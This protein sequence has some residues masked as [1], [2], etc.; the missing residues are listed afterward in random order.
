MFHFRSAHFCFWQTKV[1][2]G[3]NP[4]TVTYHYSILVAYS[5][6]VAQSRKCGI[7]SWSSVILCVGSSWLENLRRDAK[8][9]TRE[10]RLGA[11]RSTFTKSF[12]LLRGA[13]IWTIEAHKLVLLITLTAICLFSKRLR[14]SVHHYHILFVCVRHDVLEFLFRDIPLPTRCPSLPCIL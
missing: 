3:I 1:A 2:S 5:R 9:C 7:N 8:S 4:N 6:E 14:G 12:S 13:F 10:V 11:H